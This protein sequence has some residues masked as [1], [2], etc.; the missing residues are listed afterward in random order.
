[1][2]SIQVYPLAHPAPAYT[3]MVEAEHARA[4]C[5]PQ[6]NTSSRPSTMAP[7]ALHLDVAHRRARGGLSFMQDQATAAARSTPDDRVQ[8][9]VVSIK[10]HGLQEC[11]QTVSASVPRSSDSRMTGSLRACSKSSSS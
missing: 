5:R 8:R 2:N 10:S 7:S 3:L 9:S 1:M 6:R 11:V 4:V